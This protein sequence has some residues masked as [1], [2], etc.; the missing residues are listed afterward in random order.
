MSKFKSDP[1]AK[2]EAKKYDN[3][4]PSREYILEFLN[5]RGKPATRNIIASALNIETDEQYEALRRRLRAMERD[6]QLL[7]TRRGGY[8]LIEKMGLV[9]GRIIGHKD[10]FG[11]VVTEDDSG[12]VFLSARQMLSLFHGDKVLIRIAHVDK[13]G[14]REGD[15]VE[16]LERANTH[17]VG[18]FNIENNMGIVSSEN[19][20]IAQSLLIPDFEKINVQPN[21]MV[22]A[23]IIK[24]P[25]RKT[26]A[27]GKITEV[28]GRHMAPGMEVDVAL[29]TYHIPSEWPEAV[30][31]Q[32]N[33]FG[34]TVKDSDLKGRKDLRDKPFVTIDG[35]DAEDFDDAVLCEPSK[36]GGW[37]LYVAIADVSHYVQPDSELDK[38]ALNRAT[39]V[40]FPGHVIPMLPTQLS[41]E[42]CSLRP[43]RDRLVM[44]CEMS[45]SAKGRVTRAVFYEGI[46]HSKARMTYTNVHKILISKDKKLRKQYETLLPQFEA[47]YEMY[48][49]LHSQRQARGALEFETTETQ[50]IFS[51][52]RKIQ[53]IVPRQRNVAH[54][55]IEECML[56]ANVSASKFLA[57]HEIPILYR[58]HEGPKEQKLEDVRGFLAELGLKLM[59]KDKPKPKDYAKVLE[60]I[61]ER[62][63]AVLIQT[64]LLRSL[65]Q[66]V[67]TPENKGHFGLAYDHY[68][69]FT[70]P[71]R[72]YP[73]LLVHRAIRFL[74]QHHDV[75]EFNYSFSDMKRLGEHCSLNER[76]A[77]DATRDVTDWLKCEYMLD[78]VGETYSGVV[79]GVTSFG[80]FVQL[81]EIFVEGLVHISELPEDYYQFDAK[82]HRLLGERTHKTFKLTDKLTVKVAKVNLDDRQIDFVLSRL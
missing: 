6:G 78:K 11:F 47:L 26:Y 74:I 21:D 18:K 42:L 73:D 50:I 52:K 53:N 15:L 19:K 82:R 37:T 10:G 38:E 59:G 30:I 31:E 7:F 2:R 9:S 57:K 68:A 69:H 48:E 49:V 45:V 3:P 75:K 36:K 16:V 76:R 17:F 66:A 20:R 39:S 23:E 65:S 80:L 63:D 28:L 51:A 62:E 25:T 61:S 14:R 79:T 46:I 4:I 67:Y 5:E 13:K 22:V 29:K 24:Q 56:C 35:E 33:E 77:D 40:Y 44:V 27:I 34:K 58:V 12:D 32:A 54:R 41:N 60:E 8:G 71:I 55:I 72:R 43:N 1:Y 70:S 64:V 81:E